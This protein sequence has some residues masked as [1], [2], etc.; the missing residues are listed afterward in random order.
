MTDTP[1]TVTELRDLV[2]RTG[3]WE[4]TMSA[5]TN[6]TMKQAAGDMTVRV[7]IK[8][9]RQR[10]GVVDYLVEPLSG[11]GQRWVLADRVALEEV[12]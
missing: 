3:T 7:V 1:A 5:H 6:R 8:D 12:I 11:K 4:P 2:G 9:A 10:F